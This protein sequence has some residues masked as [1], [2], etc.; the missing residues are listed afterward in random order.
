MDLPTVIFS[1]LGMFLYFIPSMFAFNR[2]HDQKAAIFVLNL[3]LGWTILG[4]VG[5]L[6]WAFITPKAAVTPPL[7]HATVT[8]HE[9]FRPIEPPRPPVTRP[10]KEWDISKH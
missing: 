1:V 5:A 4:W 9:P 2:D 6:V 10:P 3:L 8:P 7:T